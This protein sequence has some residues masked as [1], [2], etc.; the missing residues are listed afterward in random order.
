M[1]QKIDKHQHI[2]YNVLTFQNYHLSFRQWIPQGKKRR[3]MRICF[4]VSI[5]VACVF[6]DLYERRIPNPLIT[7]GFL[8]G[9]SWQ[10]SSKGPPGL[11]EFL[12]GA[13][14]P[15]LLLGPLHYFR[16]LGAGDVKLFMV[17][18]GLLGP[19]EG[20]KALVFSFL[21]A[22]A[23]SAVVLFKHRILRRRLNYFVHYLHDYLQTGKWEPYIQRKE[24]AAYLHFSIPI[25]LGSLLVMGGF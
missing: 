12:A 13:A 20:L 17:T 5:G 23:C 2:I 4:L 18:G 9:I 8:L 3:K 15:L 6:C 22:A 11:W 10:W 14:L 19:Q 7:S 24:D 16:M 25:V 21:I 1:Q